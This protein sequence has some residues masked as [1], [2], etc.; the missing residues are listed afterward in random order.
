MQVFN[1]SRRSVLAVVS[2]SLMAVC[3]LALLGAGSAA[4][5]RTGDTGDGARGEAAEVVSIPAARQADRVA[6]ITVHGPIDAIT[7]MSVTRRIEAAEKA[8]MDAMVLEVDSPGGELGAVLEIS[9]AI[10]SSSIVNSVGW[11]NPDAYSGGAIIALACREI[12]TSDPASFGDAFIVTFGGG[13]LRALSPDERTKLLPPLMADVTDSARRSGYDEYLVQ[14]IVAD[15]IELW[16]AEDIETGQRLAI[17]A[18]E[19]RMLFGEDPP[20]GKPMLAEVTGGARTSRPV[21]EDAAPAGDGAE[22]QPIEEP[23]AGEGSSEEPGAEEREVARGDDPNAYRP[24]S[25]TLEDVAREFESVE[26]GASLAL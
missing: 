25:E 6:V 12:V 20:R 7:A 2:R 11:V 9:N 18:Q 24:A 22:E 15:G 21:P 13:G 26:R 19:Y 23:V 3:A 1:T 10:K 16:L 14:A 17:N 4:Q 5:D 8:G